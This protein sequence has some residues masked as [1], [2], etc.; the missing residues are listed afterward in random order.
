[1]TRRTRNNVWWSSSKSHSLKQ[2]LR[3][4]SKF[5]FFFFFFFFFSFLLFLDSFFYSLKTW[6]NI[7][8]QSE[9]DTLLVV[10][11]F[12]SFFLSFLLFGFVWILFWNVL[13]FDFFLT[14]PHW[15]GFSFVMM[16]LLFNFFFC[17]LIF[18]FWLQFIH[19]LLFFCFPGS[20]RSSD[21]SRIVCIHWPHR[22]P[23]S[24]SAHFNRWCF[25][26]NL[27]FFFSLSFFYHISFHFI[28][29]KQTVGYFKT[30]LATN[31][32]KYPIFEVLNKVK[33]H[34]SLF[35]FIPDPL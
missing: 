19:F 16:F 7:V 21:R 26:A 2:S 5:F 29:A 15:R 13:T 22:Q 23:R 11:F 17:L 33:P 31:L 34:D 28:S 24:R 14:L 10:L 8:I 6:C 3:L 12:L 35:P 9:D 32:I 1:M 18:H 27:W 30:T 25:Q 20:N 4:C